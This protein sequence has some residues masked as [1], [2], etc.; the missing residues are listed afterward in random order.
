MNAPVLIRYSLFFRS[1]LYAVRIASF[2]LPELSSTVLASQSVTLEWDRDSS[3]AVN[4]RVYHGTA[5]GRYSDTIEVGKANTATLLNLAAGKTHYFVVTAYNG[6]RESR[7][8]N[9]V[10][11][12]T[13]PTP[14]ATP[15]PPPTSPNALKLG[16][17]AL[18]PL[19][20]TGKGSLLVAQKATLTKAAILRSMT[21][22]VTKAAG[23][24]KLGVYDASGVGGGPGKLVGGTSAF[25]PNT[26]WNT[27]R[28]AY[29]VLMTPGVYWIVHWPSS[30]DLAFAKTLSRGTTY[31]YNI[32]FSWFFPKTFD[33]TKAT[34]ETVD[35]SLYAN[36]TPSAAS[37]PAPTPT[38]PPS[39]PSS[40]T[41]VI[42]NYTTNFS[43]LENPVSENGNWVNGGVTG[44]DWT[45]VRTMP[46]MAVGTMPGNA[47]GDAQYADSTAVLAGRW[48]P[49]QSAQATI[50]V[51]QSSGDSDPFEEVELRLRTTIKPYSINGY[52]INCSVST[53]P[54][55]YYM[56]IV[57][58][59]G[60]I[61][62]WTELGGRVVHAVN[63][64]VIMATANGSTITA[65]LNGSA[66]F[67]VDD[68]TFTNGS[69]G[70]GFF[71]QG[72]TGIN[73]NFGFSD[74]TAAT[75]P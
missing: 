69:P 30:N 31:S 3:P 71:L 45:N 24:L 51:A 25:T 47:G 39:N 33:L 5:S 61:G 8:S 26:G 50:F 58:W 48:G 12:T 43:R 13:S 7:P 52:E 23:W 38:P 72:A 49:N 60:P 14:T 6:A 10:S 70:I 4:Y 41:S 44:I 56:Q 66:I 11:F 35:Y 59:N 55:H 29:L 73:A 64:D 40:S 34:Q 57:R 15:D 32:A 67:S 17:T 9:E 68:G 16:E 46:G 27:V 20:D 28:V 22:Y 54:Q 19:A 65:Y 36:L 74:F 1:A 42:K 18:L 2:L 63:G 37:T 62:D 53:S 21:F 75:L